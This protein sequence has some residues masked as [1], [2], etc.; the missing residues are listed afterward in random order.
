MAD[1][2]NFYNFIPLVDAQQK[3]IDLLQKPVTYHIPDEVD[4]HNCEL[5]WAGLNG[6]E[7][8]SA[9]WNDADCFAHLNECERCMAEYRLHNR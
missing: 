1:T 4:R 7:V 6:R 5:M 8:A 9:A 3:I 2:T